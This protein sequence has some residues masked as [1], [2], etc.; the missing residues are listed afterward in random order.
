MVPF[1][2]TNLLNKVIHP[3]SHPLT[4]QCPIV[5]RGN[6]VQ[7]CENLLTFPLLSSTL[8]D[9]LKKY[10]NRKRT[11]DSDKLLP[12]DFPKSERGQKRHQGLDG[13]VF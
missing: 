6:V 1:D 5:D 7:R 13:L 8:P 9:F 2:K 3:N 10:R 11:L 12:K 4:Y